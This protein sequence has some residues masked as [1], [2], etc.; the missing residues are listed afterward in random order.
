MKNLYFIRH[1]ESVYN[2]LGKLS[3][4]TDSPLTD[5]GRE[6]AKE[7]AKDIKPLH[8]DLI[9]SS[10]LSRARETAEIIAENIGYP[11][12]KVLVSNLFVE[13]DFG[14]LE[15]APYNRYLKLRR[16][17]G[18]ERLSS[19]LD[20]SDEGLAWLKTL[21]AENILVVSHGSMGRALRHHISRFHPFYFQKHFKNAV[22]V[23]LI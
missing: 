23:K 22:V 9:V 2:S 6:Q 18:S 4:S 8:I 16:A 1:G 13:R 10:S 19:L 5:K 3:G 11:K 12:N 21:P 7:I 14:S 20:R 17:K 15:G